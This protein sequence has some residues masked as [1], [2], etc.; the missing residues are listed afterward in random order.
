MEYLETG[1]E[2]MY[3]ENKLLTLEV[4]IKDSIALPRHALLLEHDDGK[5]ELLTE[6]Y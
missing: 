3:P 1:F 6:G 2:E 5:F 4:V